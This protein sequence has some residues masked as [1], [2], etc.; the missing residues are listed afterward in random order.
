MSAMSTTY[1]SQAKKYFANEHAKARKNPSH[2][3][4]DDHAPQVV[5]HLI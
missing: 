3:T 2:S 5:V 1:Y 4:L